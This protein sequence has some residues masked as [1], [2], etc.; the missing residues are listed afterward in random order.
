MRYSKKSLHRRVTNYYIQPIHIPTISPAE[1][2]INAGALPIYYRS[3]SRL[4]AS[5]Q[6]NHTFVLI[7]GVQP[8]HHDLHVYPGQA[9]DPLLLIPVQFYFAFNNSTILEPTETTEKAL[10]YKASFFLQRSLSILV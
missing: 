1:G 8:G 9:K 4:Q 2:K 7:L 5:Q 10:Y 3:S 6:L